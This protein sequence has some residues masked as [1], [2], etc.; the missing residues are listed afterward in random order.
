MG[1]ALDITHPD[2]QPLKPFEPLVA[3]LKGNIFL[4][5]NWHDLSPAD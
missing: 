1:V 5:K 4:T 3:A 2:D